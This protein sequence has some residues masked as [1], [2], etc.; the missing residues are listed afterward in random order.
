M[1]GAVALAGLQTDS[2]RQQEQE[3]GGGEARQE[4]SQL[5]VA[6]VTGLAALCCL[7]APP[8]AMGM[9]GGN[10]QHVGSGE[11]VRAPGLPL[12]CPSPANSCSTHSQRLLGSPCKEGEEREL[13]VP[14]TCT[15]F[16]LSAL[17]SRRCQRASDSGHTRLS[18]LP[19]LAAMAPPSPGNQEGPAPRDPGTHMAPWQPPLTDDQQQLA[20]AVGSDTT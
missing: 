7:R 1:P 11:G 19:G 6:M 9:A 2:Q 12:A 16:I 3:A 15:S 5:R 8:P 4:E 13:R 10:E 20:G 18:G 14:P 17:A